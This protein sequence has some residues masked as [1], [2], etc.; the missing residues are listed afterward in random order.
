MNVVI[1]RRKY[2]P[3]D[4]VVRLISRTY[5]EERQVDKDQSSSSILLLSQFGPFFLGEFL[6]IAGYPTI[7][8]GN[9]ETQCLRYQT[10]INILV[11][12][13]AFQLKF[14]AMSGVPCLV[15]HILG[16]N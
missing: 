11:S 14:N 2:I 3:L 13:S 6:S 8:K 12:N 4:P 10:S 1:Y 16:S 7:G 5:K 15:C 9:S